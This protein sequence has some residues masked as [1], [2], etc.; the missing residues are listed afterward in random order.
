MNKARLI[1][2]LTLLAAVTAG[3]EDFTYIKSV[4]P[5]SVKM[6]MSE[7]ARNPQAT[8]L[9]GM[10]G[11]YK[12]NYTTGLELKSFLDAAH[13]YDLP[14][15]VDYVQA[16]ADGISDEK[17]N[18]QTYKK[19]N[20]NVDHVCP[21]RI[22]FD[23]YDLTKDN[24][25]RKVLRAVRSQ[26]DDQPRTNGGEFW[27]KKVYP[28]QVWL[29]G[30]YMALPFYA[31]YTARFEDEDVE[32]QYYDDIVH[33][34]ES[35]AANTKDPKTGLFRHAWDESRQMFWAD[36]ETGQSKHAWGR[37]NGWYAVALV[38]VL[39]YLPSKH[40][41]RKVLIDQLEYLLTAIKDYADPETGMWYQVLDCPGREG[42]Y[43]ESS[44]SIMFIYATLKGVN[45]RY[46][47]EEWRDYAN[48][49]YQKFLKTFVT[50]GDDG[51]I[52]IT[53]CC[54]VAG[55]GGKNNRSGDYDY[56]LSEPIIDNDCKAVG[57]FIWASLEYEASH[58]IEYYYDGKYIQDGT[59]KSEKLASKELAFSGA[60][61]GGKYSK[62]G[63]GGT[64][65]KVTTL[66]DTGEEGSL[67][68]AVEAE[69]PRIVEFAV[70]GEIHLKSELNVEHPYISIL[71]QTAPGEGIT[72]RD[73]GMYISTND[74]IIRYMRFRMGAEAGVEDDA[75]G[76][77]RC[78]NVIIDHC[79]ISWATDENLSFYACNNSTIQWCIISEPLN[80]SV[81]HKG[82]HGYGGIWGGR[83]L[84]FHHNLLA[85]NSSRNPRFDHPSI[86]R[87]DDILYRRGTVEFINNVIYNWGMK[88]AYGGEEG[89]F[90]FVGNWFKCG[91][92]ST[93]IDGR[94]LEFYTSETTSMIPGSFY[95]SNNVFD[96]TV[97]MDDGNYLGKKP[98]WKKVSLN[99]E[100]YAT[101]T[102]SA[103]F[104]CRDQYT[105]EDP[106]KLVQTVLKE[107]G[108]SKKRDDI[109]KRIVKEVKNGTAT[110]KGS[111]TG[112]P[113]IIDSVSDIQ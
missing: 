47:S 97:V 89:W 24:R 1:V 22:Y 31:Q 72:I 82:E 53:N 10:Q 18:I 64:V 28:Y 77:K 4:Q 61:G 33:Q 88:A 81:H 95:I 52:S 107:V 37:A 73:H 104:K 63:K 103:P 74:V 26:L 91:P 62:G 112:I 67:R 80:S 2:A 66:E 84:T 11:N 34:F 102:V 38:E 15:V 76:G 65:Y 8:Y 78:D 110:Y 16:W 93:S 83:N 36:P 50:T 41:G 113:G 43:L 9:D 92:G 55:L 109:D 108:A 68:Y 42:N 13:R 6:V 14:Y 35:A 99:E 70:S 87:G 90:N 48:D 79:S 3:A 45:R 57:P 71:G 56:Y 100:I 29:D 27:H 75:L 25:Y 32:N 51:L 69:G 85:H 44:A 23:L 39:D 58:N 21:A 20:Y 49:L 105:A 46:L 94:Y 40:P 7:M 60:E 106:E 101:K 111:V 5:Y 30:L 54:S 19:E 98:D 12:W 96:P 59:L 86:Y 17:G